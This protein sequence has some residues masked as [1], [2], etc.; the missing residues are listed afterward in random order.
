MISFA[1]HIYFTWKRISS[2][3]MFSP[4]IKICVFLSPVRYRLWIFQY[5]ANISTN[6][7]YETTSA[8]TV[9]TTFFPSSVCVPIQWSFGHPFMR[10]ARAILIYSVI[11]PL[12]NVTVFLITSKEQVTGFLSWSSPRKNYSIS[13]RVFSVSLIFLESTFY[14]RQ[15]N[16][17]ICKQFIRR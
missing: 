10:L 13:C 9:P 1:N 17:I 6:P 14:F 3:K 7:P 4:I 2:P 15:Y 16:K 5:R 8:I 12:E 11:H